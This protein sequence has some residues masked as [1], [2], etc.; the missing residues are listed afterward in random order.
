MILIISCPVF[1]C[2]TETKVAAIMIL[3]SGGMNL[4]CA[5][6]FTHGILY[7]IFPFNEQ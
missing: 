6:L 1:R 5:D 7:M 2:G 3:V 4:R